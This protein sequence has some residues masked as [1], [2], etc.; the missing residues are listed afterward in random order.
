VFNK[1]LDLGRN[2]RPAD[3]EQLKGHQDFFRTDIGE[4]RIVYRIE[5]DSIK[6][7]VVGKRNDSEVYKK[8]G[9]LK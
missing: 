4:Y 8:V 2:P 7:A 9:R 1:I 5:G 3:S 6:I